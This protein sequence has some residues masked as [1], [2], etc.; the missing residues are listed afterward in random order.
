MTTDN[1][2]FTVNIT[3]SYKYDYELNKIKEIIKQ[4]TDLEGI[5]K[6]EVNSK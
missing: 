1:K 3:L 4:I 2:E 6:L 5:K